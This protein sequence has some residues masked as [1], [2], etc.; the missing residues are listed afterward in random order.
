MARFVKKSVFLTTSLRIQLA[1]KEVNPFCEIFLK[2][3]NRFKLP[4]LRHFQVLFCAV[5]LNSLLTIQSVFLT[6]SLRIQLAEKE[7]NPFCEIFLKFHNRF[8]LP[9]LRHFQVLFCAVPLN[10]LLT[11]LDMSRQSQPIRLIFFFFLWK[12]SQRSHSA[13]FSLL[14]FRCSIMQRTDEWKSGTP[15]RQAVF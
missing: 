14:D 11:I 9:Y 8:K 4:Y 13:L 6:T 10:S 7:V 2:F 5:P 15:D 12:R 3:H 1:E